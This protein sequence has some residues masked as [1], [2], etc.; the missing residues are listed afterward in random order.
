MLWGDTALVY[1]SSVNER[2]WNPFHV[3]L[4]DSPRCTALNGLFT[5]ARNLYG[6]PLNGIH[7]QRRSGGRGDGGK[8]TVVAGEGWG[9]VLES[10]CSAQPET[11]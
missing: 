2:R 4:P 10:Q 6:R 9:F 3:L 11:L 8:E 5:V 1:T 7:S